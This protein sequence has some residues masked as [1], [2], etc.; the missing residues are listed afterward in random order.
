[1]KGIGLLMNVLVINAGSSSLK[2]QLFNMKTEAI[3]AKGICDRIGI[4]GHLK[5]TPVSNGKPVFNSDIPLPTHAEA[6]SAVIEKLT[7]ADYGVIDSLSEINAVGHRTVHGGRRFV[8]SV[9]INNEV[10]SAIED[11][12]RLAPLHIPANLM[13]IDACQKAMPEVPQVAVFDTAF[14]HT[15]PDYAYIYPIPY[16]YYEENDI[17]RYGFHGTSHRYVSAIA[18]DHLGGK[19]EGTKLITCHLGNGSSLAA[20]K[21]GKS[22]DTTMGVTPLEGVPMGTRCGSVD[23]SLPEIIAS[24]EGISFKETMD[25]LNKKSG[26]LGISGTSSDFR[27]IEEAAGIDIDTGAAIKGAKADKRAALALDVFNY[28]VAKFIGSYMAV[29]GGL[30]AL[31][32]TAGIG[33]N[34]PCTRKGICDLLEGLGIRIDEEKN[35]VRAGALLDIT[36][37]GSN[38]KVLVIPTNEELVIA[39][40]TVEI[41]KDM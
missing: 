29:M 31:I 33:E 36:G 23:P 2:Y 32:F 21:D 9:L 18:I 14:H 27:D 10:H 38:V 16:K 7:S 34:S 5:H 8:A 24:I 12:V 37:K 19:A 40:D 30:D 41:V 20:V 28:Q 6:L 4:D 13:G 3:L 22:V 17:R 39:R 15:I 11:C 26:V 1:M 35:A 25:I